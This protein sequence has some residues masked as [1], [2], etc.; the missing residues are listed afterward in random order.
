MKEIILFHF[1]QNILQG[2]VPNGF[3]KKPSL[4]FLEIKKP[5]VFPPPSVNSLQTRPF[6][7]T[8]PIQAYPRMELTGEWFA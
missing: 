2:D 4:Q 1:N 3:P 8:H 5:S 7:A 6:R